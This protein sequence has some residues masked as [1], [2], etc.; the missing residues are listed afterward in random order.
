MDGIE[1]AK[2]PVGMHE[3]RVT[4]IVPRLEQNLRLRPRTPRLPRGPVVDAAG[5]V[6]VVEHYPAPD[7]F[8]PADR[9]LA[10]ARLVEQRDGV[11]FI[12]RPKWISGRVESREVSQG[13][14]VFDG[15]RGLES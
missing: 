12:R 1:I 10:H 13:R 15:A 2:G 8:V 11:Q 7:E 6:A 4:K 14:N 9:K 3:M 5:R